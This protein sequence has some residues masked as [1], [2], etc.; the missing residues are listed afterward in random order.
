MYEMDY[1]KDICMDIQSVN[2]LKNLTIFFYFFF[3][4]KELG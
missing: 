1:I 4:E 3:K 2:K